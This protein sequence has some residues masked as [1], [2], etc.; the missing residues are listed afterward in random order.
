MEKIKNRIQ[1]CLN[2]VLSF[3][4][5]SWRFFDDKLH[6]VII[7]TFNGIGFTIG[8]TRLEINLPFSIILFAWGE[9]EYMRNL[10]YDKKSRSVKIIYENTE[11]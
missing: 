1:E 2:E 10:F 4:I 6:F 3:G 5:T 7:D 11:L 9:R 8:K